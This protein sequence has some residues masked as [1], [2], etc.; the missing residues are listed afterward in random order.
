MNDRQRDLF[1]TRGVHAY[2]TAAQIRSALT[3]LGLSVPARGDRL[4]RRAARLDR[5]RCT[6]RDL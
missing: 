5:E 4:D 3:L 2:D 6:R 1:L